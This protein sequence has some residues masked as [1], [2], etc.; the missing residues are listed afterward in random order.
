[1]AGTE[2]KTPEDPVVDINYAKDYEQ[3]D[4]RKEGERVELSFYI[5]VERLSKIDLVNQTFKCQF[6]LDL[7]WR[8][9]EEDV[10]R[11]AEDKLNYR[12]S[13]IP[14]L[15]FPNGD[16]DREDI[17]KIDGREFTLFKAGE[18]DVWGN[19]FSE[20]QLRYK[21]LNQCL[22]TVSGEFSEP[23]ELKNFPLDVQDFT[24]TISTAKDTNHVVFEPVPFEH[25][26]GYLNSRFMS[27]ADFEM[28]KP[29]WE[30]WV[31]SVEKE[32][33]ETLH[34]SLATFRMKMSRIWQIYFWR[35]GIF[36]MIL[37]FCSLAVFTL[38]KEDV[39]SRYETLLT[40][41]LAAVA[42]QYI[43][44]SELP[45]LPYL[46]LMDIYVL[47]SFTFVFVV[48]VLVSISG[49][50]EVEQSVD[51]LFFC[52]A[53][54]I[55]VIF[56]VCF[57]IKGYRARKY[58]LRKIDFSRWDYLKHGYDYVVGTEVPSFDV[59]N[60]DIRMDKVS[61]Q[62]ILERSWWTANDE[63]AKMN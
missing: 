11:Y 41:L 46:T 56:H 29:I 12:P 32:R 3:G 1:M 22:I 49:Y 14:N 8:A 44:N 42:F 6:D 19:V 51:N 27:M 47:F 23:F 50:F 16:I 60:K 59:W 38:D 61:K 52:V 31:E 21:Y 35:I 58:E 57:V 30:F 45:K 34:W 7:T 9:T 37:S 10:R 63:W 26:N 13:H 62:K 53:L 48:I 28:H 17:K 54:L 24:I 36:T 4:Y 15:R 55:F 20:D 5:N 40:L 25:R 39:A 2:T 43:I 33:F 18:G